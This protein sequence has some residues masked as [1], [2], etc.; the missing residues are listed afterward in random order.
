MRQFAFH[1]F[2]VHNNEGGCLTPSL[3]G[4]FLGS[5]ATVLC[6]CTEEGMEMAPE[7]LRGIITAASTTAVTSLLGKQASLLTAAPT[8]AVLCCSVPGL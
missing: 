8:P 1:L 3:L 5:F 7:M 2:A 4:N 6:A